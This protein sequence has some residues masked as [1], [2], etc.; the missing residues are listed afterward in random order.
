MDQKLQTSWNQCLDILRDNLSSTAFRTW[1]APII[2]MQFENKILVLQVK[3]EFIMEYIE[4]NYLDLLAKTLV[5]VFG[6]GVRLEYRVL[7]DSH[8]GTSHI[9]PSQVVMDQQVKRSTSTPQVAYGA[10]QS[11]P[12]FQSQLNK[13]YTFATFVAGESNKMAHSVGQNIAKAPGRLFNPLFIYGGSGV[14]K[15]HLANAIGN[16]VLQ[17]DPS[18]RVLYVTANTF[19]VQYSEAVLSNKVNDFV[20]FYRTID[21]LIVD[22]VQY[23]ADKKGTQ[24]TFFF[25]FNYL[26]QSGKQLI[27]TSDCAP[28]DLKGL[29][30]RLITRFKWG[31]M[32]EIQKPD[33]ALRKNIL[34][35]R[36]Y[37]DGL[38]IDDEIVDYIAGNVNQNVRDLEGVIASLLAYSTLTDANIDLELAQQV[39]ARMV[40]VNTEE[41]SID[42]ITEAVC[43]YYGISEKSLYASTRKHEVAQA[44]QVAMYLAKK[45]T[46]KSLIEIGREMGNRNHATVIHAVNT[47]TKTME[48]D[49]FLKRS[50]QQLENTLR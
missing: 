49:S 35:S 32:A 10:N 41:L 18:K 42:N 21:V 29:E 6:K 13:S 46:K 34:K 19:Q 9:I 16:Q 39:I 5:R 50:I 24:S 1:F 23:W 33:F 22:D 31:V 12:Q 26:H 8:S 7:I 11:M 43:E 30:D 17:N 45:L 2:P 47:I 27:L 36:I 15:T 20:N 3:S 38:D 40:R 28:V 37:Q 48:T 14:G 25:I 4:D 44:R